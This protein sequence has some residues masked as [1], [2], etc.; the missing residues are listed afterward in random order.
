MIY[1]FGDT[2]GTLEINRL[3]NANLKRLD[4]CPLPGEGDFVIIAGD[5]GL[6]WRDAPDNEERF[7][8]KWLDD[9][10]YETLF[11][12]GNHENFPRI[13]L[14]PEEDWHGGR[15]HRI[16]AKVRHLMRG[17]V[18]D[19][20]GLSVLA[21]G[22]ATSHDRQFRQEGLSWWPEELPSEDDFACAEQSLSR[23]GWEV[24]LVVSHCAPTLVQGRLDPT[25]LPDRATEWLELLRDRLSFR[26]WFFGHYHLDR[27]F[28]DG[29]YALYDNVAAVDAQGV[30]LFSE[31]GAKRF[32]F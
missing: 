15:V 26:A 25:F 7:W 21:F 32:D 12:D 6:I 1:L 20:D 19:I 14:Y 13:A 22:G 11:V 17:Q 3:S 29:F 23:R 9:K 24:D 8:M 31:D 27:A 5:F 18:Y 30:H 28:Y 2:H 10:P 16:S 4:V